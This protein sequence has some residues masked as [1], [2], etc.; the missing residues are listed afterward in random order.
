MSLS[1][2]LLLSLPSL[3]TLL[4]DTSIDRRVIILGVRRQVSFGMQM[5]CHFAGSCPCVIVADHIR[6]REQGRSCSGQVQSTNS[7]LL[8]FL[9]RLTAN[10]LVSTS[11]PMAYQDDRRSHTKSIEECA[12]MLASIKLSHHSPLLLANLGL[13][14]S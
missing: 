12:V 5:V 4:P 1:R 7:E 3:F 11:K 8:I 14:A 13:N 10:N 2:V 9:V 6:E